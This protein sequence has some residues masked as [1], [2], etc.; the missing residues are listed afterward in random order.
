[1]CKGWWDWKLDK[2]KNWVYFGF[3]AVRYYM[4]NSWRCRQSGVTHS[5]TYG[6][7]E[8][9]THDHAFRRHL[10]YHWATSLYRTSRLNCQMVDFEEFHDRKIVK[11]IVAMIKLANIYTLLSCFRQSYD[12]EMEIVLDGTGVR[13]SN[14]LDLKNP[15]F[16]YVQDDFIC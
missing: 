11:F 1:M 4:L 12:V 8:T 10:L 3:A 14:V 9:G 6:L 5:K 16:R 2:Q 13:S 15:Y 7:G